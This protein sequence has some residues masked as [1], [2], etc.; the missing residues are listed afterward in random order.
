MPW[1]PEFEINHELKMVQLHDKSNGTATSES[2]NDSIQKTIDTAI[3]QDIFEIIHGQHSEPIKIV[4]AKYLVHVERF[5][6]PL[7]GIATRGAHMTC[8][9]RA[10]SGE[11]KIWTPKRSRHIFTY[12]GKLDTTVAGGIKAS[13][14][15]FKCIVEESSEEASLPTSFVEEHAKAVGVLTYLTRSKR[16]GLIHPD[17]VYVYDLELPETIEP[18]PNDDEVEEFKLMGIEEIKEAMVNGEF[19]SNC[20][21]VTIDFFIRHGVLKPEEEGDYAEIMQRLHRRLPFPV[22]EGR[23]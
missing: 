19:K 14:T 3:S 9:T 2:C 21:L 20:N 22:L 11:M 8:Y 23:V 17:I 7:F 13:H 5:A 18:K 12:P 6:A 10:A 15:P 4:G 16:S 1:S